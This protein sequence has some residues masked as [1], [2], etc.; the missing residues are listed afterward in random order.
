M[1]K[2]ERV[3]GFVA[4]TRFEALPAEVV[5]AARRA[6]LDTLG[7]TIA[8]A[9]EAGSRILLDWIAP[10]GAMQGAHIFGTDRRAPAQQAALA[11]GMLG[12]A[13]DFDDVSASLSGHPSVPV[14]PAVLAV[15]ETS[16]QSGRAALAAFA[17]GLEVECKLGRALGSGSYTRGWHATSVVG[18]I[19]AAA[20][21]ARLM[22]LD[23][24][25]VRHALG[26]AAS[27]ACGTRQ[28]FG[29]M[30]KPLHAGL[31]ARAG[32]EAAE[33]AARG[34]T[35]DPCI[36]EAPLGFGVLFSPDGDWHPE[37]FGELGKPWDLVTPGISVKKYP[38]CYMTHRAL[39][40]ALSATGARPHAATEIDRIEVHVPAGSVS[41]LIHHRPSTGLE[42]KFSM[43]Y[44]LAAALLDGAVRLSSFQDDAV[45]RPEA[46]ALLRRVE[47]A[48]VPTVELSL[49]ASARVTVKLRNGN[50]LDAEVTRERGDPTDPLSWDELADKYRDCAGRR[51]P[52]QQVERSLALIASFEKT[53]VSGLA[54]ILASGEAW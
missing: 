20:A 12:H 3:A 2:T 48:E 35:A 25:S 51:L 54:E 26:I 46:Q 27:M 9:S 8:G 28:N 6:I 7:V 40:A 37:R 45:Q 41:A 18:A 32:V 53:Q 19:G 34:F 30:T 24:L 23:V 17:V 39:D 36:L 47:I 22:E 52:P 42:G 1:L 31:A 16:Q 4:E 43:E 38:C 13:L 5:T 44:C 33:L 49:F 11:N 29:T 14:L 15:A 21:C 50:S 10:A